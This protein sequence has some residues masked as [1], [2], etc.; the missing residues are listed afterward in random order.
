MHSVL[1]SI[2]RRSNVFRFKLSEDPFFCDR[3]PR[4]LT[5]PSRVA[6]LVDEVGTGDD[7]PNDDGQL[8]RSLS[9][10]HFCRSP[11][12][13]PIDCLSIAYRQNAAGGIT[14]LETGLTGIVA[15]TPLVMCC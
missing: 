4:R 7:R 2:A 3:W 5:L 14:G 12:D 10:C 15:V 13:I 1:D 6:G 8:R 11:G 9:S